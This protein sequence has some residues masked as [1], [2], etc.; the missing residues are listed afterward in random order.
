MENKEELKAKLF[1]NAKTGWEGISKEDKENIFEYCKQY[2][3]FLNNSKTEREIVKSS[4]EL[5]EKNGF[6][7]ICEY[8]KLKAGDKVY[9][10]NRDKSMYLAIIGQ[11]PIEN[12]INIIG[13]HADSPRLDLKPNPLYEDSGLAFLKTHYYGGIKKYQWTT[14]PLAIHGVVV[15]ANG[16][17]IEVKIGED[18]E[19]PIFTI[20]DLL[21]HLA[22]EQ[23]ER[24]LKDGVHGEDLNILIGSIPFEGEKGAEAVKLNIMNILNQKYGITEMDFVSSELEIVPAFRAR[25]MGFD[26]SMVAAYGQD[27]KICVYTSLTALLK[28]ENPKTTAVCIISDKEEIGSVGAT[29]MHSR[30]FENTVAE[31]L[32]LT[33]DYNDL[34]LRRTLQNSYMLSSDVSA[35]FDPN[36]PSVMEKKNCAYFGKGL[37]LNKYTGARGKSGSND[38]NPE[39][40]AQLRKIFDEA[41]VAFQTAELGKVDEGGGGT[42]AYIPAAYSMNVI[43][44]GVAVLSMHAPWEITSK[45]DIYE[46]EKGYEAFLKNCR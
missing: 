44:C 28:L 21:P 12:G 13:S 3:Q 18:D 29:G 38:A 14:I 31:I 4:K 1:R 2:M 8:E 23:M 6:K 37:V 20:T 42:I 39:Y 30:F 35:A 9:Y 17:K 33:G 26:S 43:D 27:D 5:A 34:R 46:V 22:Q 24:K 36:Y 15:K 41:K 45:S 19:D 11:N 7:S 10:I 32:A 40:I 16:E 25:S